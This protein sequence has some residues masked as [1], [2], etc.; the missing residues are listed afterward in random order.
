M[1]ARTDGGTL[2]L[3]GRLDGR[4][5]AQ[6]RDM[7]WEQI[8]DYDDLVVDLSGVESIDGAALR[9]L[10]A[11]ST[12]LEREGRTLVLRGCAPA[13]RRVIAFTKMRSVLQVERERLGA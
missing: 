3:V 5:T 8:A 9:M 1:D 4:S 2:I 11:T 6:V 13:V 10:A 12:L 7:L